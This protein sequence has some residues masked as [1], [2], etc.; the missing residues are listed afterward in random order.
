MIQYPHL[1]TIGYI[2][3]IFSEILQIKVE[4]IILSQKENKIEKARSV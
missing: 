3:T 1:Q 2:H 4:L